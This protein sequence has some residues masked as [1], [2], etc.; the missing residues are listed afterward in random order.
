MIRRI[1]AAHT[2]QRDEIIW[3][4]GL[5]G[6]KV[7][8]ISYRKGLY[9]INLS[10][11]R[12]TN[13]F[14]LEICNILKYESYLLSIDLQHNYIGQK[15]IT[16]ALEMIE[17]NNGLV[18]FDVRNNPGY[19]PKITSKKIKLKLK[20][21]IKFH[22]KNKEMKCFLYGNKLIDKNFIKDKR[23]TKYRR[24]NSMINLKS[25]IRFESTKSDSRSSSRRNTISKKNR[26]SK[27]NESLFSIINKKKTSC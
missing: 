12:L 7:K 20:K 2:E 6:E 11:N 22:N 16:E 18:Y 8:G 23:N 4:L 25:P 15:G 14:M 19:D 21:N 13:K 10:N 1:I 3:L 5:R 17:E 26:K 27:I 9:K 24:V